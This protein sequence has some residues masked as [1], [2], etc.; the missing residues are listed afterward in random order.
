MDR[1]ASMETFVRVVE[2]GSFSGAARQ[3]RIGQPAVSKAVSQLESRLG[4]KLLTRSTKGLT[5]TEA[6]L[7]YFQRAKRSIEEADAGSTLAGRRI[8]TSVREHYVPAT[9]HLISV[10]STRTASSCR[11][12]ACAT[13]RFANPPLPTGLNRSADYRRGRKY[14]RTAPARVASRPSHSP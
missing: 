6:G 2:T 10:P 14:R 1:L 13:G 12:R 11:S 7:A 3:L 8:R 5:L 9:S 4:V